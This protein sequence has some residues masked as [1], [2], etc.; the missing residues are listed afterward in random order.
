MPKDKK[1]A[2]KIYRDQSASMKFTAA[3]AKALGIPVKG[4]K[5]AVA[6]KVATNNVAGKLK[7]RRQ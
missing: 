7:F 2:P 3:E 5:P 1:P 6:E 4:S